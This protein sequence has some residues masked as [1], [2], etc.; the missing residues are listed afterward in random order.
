MFSI[1]SD[2]TAELEEQEEMLE[3]SEE[4]TV[5][6]GSQP[7]KTEEKDALTKSVLTISPSTAFKSTQSVL[8]K[9]L[10]KV[11][12]RS[13]S[14]FNK[15]STQKFGSK[16]TF[17]SASSLEEP[18]FTDDDMIVHKR[19]KTGYQQK[20][21]LRE[22]YLNFLY[23]IAIIR[24]KAAIFRLFNTFQQLSSI[25]DRDHNIIE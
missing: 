3:Q 18:A 8:D 2:I 20:L 25:T 7:N 12:S 19:S 9:S 14:K 5:S 4:W 24:I 11:L 17:L 21:R 22:K 13:A 1:I 10:S 16:K 23:F 6:S 15:S